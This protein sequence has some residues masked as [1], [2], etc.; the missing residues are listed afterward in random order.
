MVIKRSNKWQQYEIKGGWS[1]LD[2]FE[3]G[4]TAYT[5]PV[6]WTTHLHYGNATLKLIGEAV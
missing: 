5:E 2:T 6:M 4:F 3:R 1:P